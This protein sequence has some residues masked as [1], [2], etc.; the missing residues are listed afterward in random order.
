MWH[1]VRVSVVLEFCVCV[2]VSA[3]CLCY[4]R[5]VVCVSIVLGVSSVCGGLENRRKDH[6]HGGGGGVF[7]REKDGWD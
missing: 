5:S 7:C 3:I 6:H 2:R 1:C 4:A